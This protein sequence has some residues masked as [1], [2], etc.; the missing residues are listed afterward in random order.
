[1]KPWLRACGATAVDVRK[2]EG[3]SNRMKWP[4]PQYGSDELE[5]FGFIVH[6]GPLPMEWKGLSFPNVSVMLPIC[7][8]PL[9]HS[10]SK[11]L[12]SHWICTKP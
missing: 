7:P 6:D 2:Q 9:S 12:H 4:F 3:S 1:M 11:S 10:S 5:D 8:S